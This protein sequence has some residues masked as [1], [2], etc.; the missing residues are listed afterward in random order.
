ML[1]LLLSFWKTKPFPDTH[2]T[3]TRQQVNNHVKVKLTNTIHK[4][5]LTNELYKWSRPR[6]VLAMCL[7]YTQSSS[8]DLWRKK[9]KETFTVNVLA[10]ANDLTLLMH[11]VK[12]AA[13][14]ISFRNDRA[15]VVG[16]KVTTDKTAFATST[17]DA[18]Y[19]IPLNFTACNTKSVKH[20]GKWITSNILQALAKTS[21]APNRREP[22]TSV[23]ST[24]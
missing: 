12:Q 9:H 6:Q 20:L 24:N 21:G 19:S 15:A 4:V 16:S 5:K 23:R 3:G 10:F 7:A 22:S 11:G 17:N 14:L 1:H 2:R 13:W 18:V 8:T